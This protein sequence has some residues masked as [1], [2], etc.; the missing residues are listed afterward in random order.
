VTIRQPSAIAVVIA[1]RVEGNIRPI[2]D[3]AG[4]VAFGVAFAIVNRILR[5]RR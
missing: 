3:V 2:L 5:G 4:A 1:G